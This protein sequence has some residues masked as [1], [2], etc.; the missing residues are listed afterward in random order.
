MTLQLFKK[1]PVEKESSH[2]MCGTILFLTLFAQNKFENQFGELYALETTA[3][4][5][6]DKMHYEQ[7]KEIIFSLIFSLSIYDVTKKALF[8][9]NMLNCMKT[10]K[11]KTEN[12]IVETTNF[13]IFMPE[14]A[15]YIVPNDATTFSASQLL[16]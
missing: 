12:S 8:G 5:V 14:R 7:C 1:V 6:R 16:F 15:F 13:T 11:N 9:R 2:S 3:Q 10:S 4:C